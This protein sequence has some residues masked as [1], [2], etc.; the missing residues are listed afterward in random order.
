MTIFNRIWLQGEKCPSEGNKQNADT[1][2]HGAREG[3]QIFVATLEHTFAITC[4]PSFG[5]DAEGATSGLS[6]SPCAMPR[7]NPSLLFI[8]F[9]F[10]HAKDSKNLSYSFS[11][12]GFH[13][14][15][16]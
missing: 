1:N 12:I 6:F 14:L 8:L 10:K 7:S 16:S 5:G 15:F 9:G 2:Y 4:S 3:R 13:L 11:E